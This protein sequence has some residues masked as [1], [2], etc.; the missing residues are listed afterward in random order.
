M[1]KKT[2]LIIVLIISFFGLTFPVF[3]EDKAEEP[4]KEE[5]SKNCKNR[6]VGAPVIYYTPETR[7]AYGGAASFVTRFWGCENGT[8][9]S[10]F[11][12]LMIFTQERQFKA[13]LKNEIYFK[14]N[15]Y[16]LLT[17]IKTE[18]YPNKFFGVG[19]NTLESDKEL[20]TSRSTS[21]LISLSKGLGK[22]FNIGMEYYYSHWNIIEKEE[23]GLLDS[24]LYSGS[25]SGTLSAFGFLVNHDTRDNIYSAT[26]GDFVE[27]NT[28]IYP[29]FLG[30]TYSFATFSLDARKYFSVFK[31][32][33]IALQGLLK[34]Q[35]GT[36]PFMNYAQLGG[37]YLMRGYFEGRYRDK[38]L[39][40]IQTE[41][42]MP[43][44]WRFDIVGF[45]G[46]GNVSSQFDT[47]LFKFKPSYGLGIRFMFDK[48]ERIQVR[49]DY[50]WGKG[51]NGF[52]ASIF[53]AF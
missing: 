51:T 43:L 25:N 37:Q 22:G 30:S 19:N 33:V 50:G 5:Q 20:Y 31:S 16:R 52:Y 7:L 29:K 47:E 9:P 8:R 21:F 2:I 15:S 39:L 35:S 36:V 45:L 40:A 13:L 48:R 46:L 32:H 24:G 10:S 26:T 11:S 38:N 4:K 1:L 42:R 34:V 6:I 3:G 27:F 17:E 14:N 28:R 53:Q 49:L 18:K 44:V 23:G 12:P 41:Y